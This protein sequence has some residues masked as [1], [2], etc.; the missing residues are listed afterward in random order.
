MSRTETPNKPTCQNKGRN[1]LLLSASQ[2]HIST[3]LG[4][5]SQGRVYKPHKEEHHLWSRHV[6]QHTLAFKG[7]A[8]PN[9]STT[10]ISVGGTYVSISHHHSTV[11]FLCHYQ[12]CIVFFPPKVNMTHRDVLVIVHYELQ[13]SFLK[14]ETQQAINTHSIYSNYPKIK[15]I[16]FDEV[17]G[18]IRYY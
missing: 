17:S 6:A 14:H 3:K 9:Q 4:A 1:P 16:S 18:D 5:A 8:D 2:H 10:P 12:H 7:H 11:Y 13:F 15:P